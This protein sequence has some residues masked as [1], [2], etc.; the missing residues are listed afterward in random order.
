MTKDAS[1]PVATS[2]L[3]T[4]AG[5]LLSATCARLLSYT[6]SSVSSIEVWTDGVT[7]TLSGPAP[8]GTVKLNQSV[9]VGAAMIPVTLNVGPFRVKL[10]PQTFP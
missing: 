8:T 10:V 4:A 7:E 5:G 9:S 1:R 6:V 3:T 2:L